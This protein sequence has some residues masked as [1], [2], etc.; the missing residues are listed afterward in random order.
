M[1]PKTPGRLITLVRRANR[2]ACVMLPGA[3]GGINPYLGLAV[4]IGETHN[5]YAVRAAGLMPDEKPEDT[6][7]AMVTS[8]LEALDA[9]A[10]VPEL[11]FGWSLGGVVGWELCVQLAERN[12]LPDLV[13]VDSSPLPRESTTDD[14][15]RVLGVILRMLGPRPD[16]ATVDR[17]RRTFGAQMAALTGY[18]ARRSYPGRVL[19]LMCSDDEFPTRAESA[20]RWRSLAPNLRTGRVDAD[21]FGV[22]DPVPLQQLTG[23]IAMFLGRTMEVTRCSR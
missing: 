1:A 7:D 22:F 14:D 3:G 6:I 13:L 15:A 12:L 23:Q 21:H 11:V 17:V 4:F 8:A 16:P 9:Q 5:V 2:P 10:I 18:C 19:M 20:S